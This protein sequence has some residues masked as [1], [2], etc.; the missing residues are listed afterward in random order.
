MLY[1]ITF[2]SGAQQE[3]DLDNH[4]IRQLAEGMESSHKEG[5]IGVLASGSG[6][7]LINEVVGAHPYVPMSRKYE[8]GQLTQSL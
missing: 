2:K 6:V 3:F 5:I 8:V 7:I 1:T 4:A